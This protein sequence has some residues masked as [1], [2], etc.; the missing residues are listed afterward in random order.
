MVKAQPPANMGHENVWNSHP[1]EYGKGGRTWWVPDERTLA[2]AVQSV[3]RLRG[4]PG[5]RVQVSSG[6][7]AP[8]LSWGERYTSS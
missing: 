1:K 6:I 8:W 4:T 7:A 2:K 5:L 3:D